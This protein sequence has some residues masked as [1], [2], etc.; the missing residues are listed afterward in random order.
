MFNEF[1]NELKSNK[2]SNKEHISEFYDEKEN[3]NI[4]ISWVYNFLE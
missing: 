1:N 2:I 4:D 3:R